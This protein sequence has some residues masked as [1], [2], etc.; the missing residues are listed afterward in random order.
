VPKFRLRPDRGRNGSAGPAVFGYKNHVSI[1][2]THAFVCRFA[3][4][5]AAAQDG[6]QLGTVLDKT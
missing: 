2:R 4:T 6:V 1:D 3:A 5:S